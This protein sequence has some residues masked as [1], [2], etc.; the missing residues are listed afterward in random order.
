M[1]SKVNALKT[2]EDNETSTGGTGESENID[3]FE[4]IRRLFGDDIYGSLQSKSYSNFALRRTIK[5]S[6]YF[7]EVSWKLPQ[8]DLRLSIFVFFAFSK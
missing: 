3:V 2:S 7:S 1:A 6:R 4:K 8:H 5:I